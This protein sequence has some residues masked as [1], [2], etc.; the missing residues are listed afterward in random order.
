MLVTELCL[1]QQ[2]CTARDTP[3]TTTHR[4]VVVVLYNYCQTQPHPPASK[5]KRRQSELIFTHQTSQCRVLAWGVVTDSVWLV[6][7]DTKSVRDGM[8][9]PRIATPCASQ[10][11]CYSLCAKVL[12]VCYIH[13]T[14]L[15]STQSMGLSMLRSVV[16][17]TLYIE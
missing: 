11:Y 13:Y 12:K 9:T 2:C 14:V 10:K 7:A 8:G 15:D 4:S 16:V 6:F 5:M 1:P 17:T 3:H